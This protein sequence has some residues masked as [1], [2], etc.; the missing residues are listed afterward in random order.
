MVP[1]LCASVPSVPSVIEGCDGYLQSLGH[2]YQCYGALNG[3]SDKVAYLIGKM[4]DDF[5]KPLA[6]VPA[7]MKEW[8][9]VHNLVDGLPI[10]AVLNTLPFRRRQRPSHRNR[11]V[12]TERLQSQ[13]R[14]SAG[15]SANWQ[16]PTSSDRATDRSRHATKHR[17]GSA[18]LAEDRLWMDQYLMV[19]N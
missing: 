13:P 9:M 15:N 3:D 16:F 10:E 4:T 6:G 14:Q 19:K 11:F 8:H 1:T 2:V 17:R 7:I 18:F 5:A 12:D